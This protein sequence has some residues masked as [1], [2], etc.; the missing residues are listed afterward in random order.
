LAVP[1]MPFLAEVNL[2]ALAKN[3][4]HLVRAGKPKT[5]AYFDFATQQTKE[6]FTVEKELTSARAVSTDER[7]VLMTQLREIHG[8]I[9]PMGPKR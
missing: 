3:G 8:E 9:M 1:G 5:L 7:S 4:I 2:W 6:L